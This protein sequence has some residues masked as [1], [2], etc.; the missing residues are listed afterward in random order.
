MFSSFDR[1]EESGPFSVTVLLTLKLLCGGTGRTDGT[2]DFVFVRFFRFL[3]II[4]NVACTLHGFLV[5]CF[6]AEVC[7][8]QLL[9]TPDLCFL[10]SLSTLC[11]HILYTTE[12]IYFVL[13]TLL[14]VYMKGSRPYSS[15]FCMYVYVS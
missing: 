10:L 11:A 14:D 6:E 4:N 12:L 2:S 9:Q 15:A 8:F 7:P 13:T 5:E 3:K 1:A